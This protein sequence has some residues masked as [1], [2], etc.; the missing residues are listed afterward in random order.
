ML[1]LVVLAAGPGPHRLNAC[2]K[3]LHQAKVMRP[4]RAA[5]TDVRSALA[6]AIARLE[7]EHVPSAALAAELLLMHALET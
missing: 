6:D 7:R 3:T 4:L 1:Q 5:I 2:H